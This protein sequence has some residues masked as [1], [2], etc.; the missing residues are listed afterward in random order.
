MGVL[1]VRERLPAVAR[2]DAATD[3]LLG[4]GRV[5]DVCTGSVIESNVAVVVGKIALVDP[6]RDA[7]ETV[8]LAGRALVPRLIDAHV[9]LESFTVTP[10]EFARAV[11]PRGPL[12]WSRIPTRSP[13]SPGWPGSGGR[14]TVP[15]A[16][17]WRC[18]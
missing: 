16:C 13:M 4:G 3:L 7:A 9:H 2:G 11:V 8:D 14:S 18:W 5:V 1:R 15:R 12:P 17:H 10:S 6:A